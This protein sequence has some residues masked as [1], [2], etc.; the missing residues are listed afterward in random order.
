MVVTEA[1]AALVSTTSAKALTGALG[2]AS[3]RLEA[4]VITTLTP[5]AAQLTGC[6]LRHDSTYVTVVYIEDDTNR[7]DGTLH[8]TTTRT[9]IGFSN[10][11][12]KLPVIVG[13]ASVEN[14]TVRFTAMKASGRAWAN[15]VPLAIAASQTPTAVMTGQNGMG[16][17]L[18]KPAN[19]AISTTE[20]TLDL[21]VCAM[22]YSSDY[23]VAVYVS[24]AGGH[25][26][27]TVAAASFS[28]PPSSDFV[29]PPALTGSIST[30][31]ADITFQA[32]VPGRLWSVIVSKAN[33]PLVTLATAKSAQLWALGALSCRKIAQPATAG[34]QTLSFTGCDLSYA[35]SYTAFTYIED[36]NGVGDGTLSAPLDIA[37]PGSS[38]FTTAPGI[39]QAQ[40]NSVAFFFQASHTGSALVWAVVG[41]PA[42]VA[43]L[44]TVSVK[45]GTG[46]ICGISGQA[47]TTGPQSMS[48]VGCTLE[49]GREYHL[50]AYIEAR[51]LTGTLS[52]P[53]TVLVP[54]SN[55]FSG[56][57]G[58]HSPNT[59]GVDVLFA[60]QTVGRAWGV[61]VLASDAANVSISNIKAGIGAIGG[62]CKVADQAVNSL[63]VQTMSFTGCSL[64]M[65][66]T[67]KAFVYVEDGN[68]LEDGTLSDPIDVVL[69]ASNW[70][71][72]GPYE[73]HTPTS[74]ATSYVLRTKENGLLWSMITADLSSKTAAEIKAMTVSVGGTCGVS[75]EPVQYTGDKTIN[76][77]GCSLTAG[78]TYMAH[79]YVEDALGNLDGT[80]ASMPVRVAPASPGNSFQESPRL[81][82]NSISGNG[83]G[84]SYRLANAG[85]VHAIVV[86][87]GTTV[88]VSSLLSGTDAVGDAGCSYLPSTGL[89]QPATSQQT[90][91]FTGCSLMGDNI[92]E[93][94]VYT[95]DYPGSWPTGAAALDGVM[96]G[97]IEI[98]IPFSNQVVGEPE[99][100]SINGLG[101][102]IKFNTTAFHGYAWLTVY[103]DNSG[104]ETNLSAA[105]DISSA[106]CGLASQEVGSWDIA[107]FQIT[108]CA[109]LG[110]VQYQVLLLVEDRNGN[111][112]GQL[113]ILN[114]TSIGTVPFSNTFSTSPVIS[115]TVTATD[116]AVTYAAG[117]AGQGFIKLLGESA[118]QFVDVLSLEAA[119]ASDVLCHTPITT[120]VAGL[121]S[122]R[123]TGCSLTHG[124][125]YKVYVY[126]TDS[127]GYKDGTLSSPLTALVAPGRSNY[128]SQ[129]AALAPSTLTTAGFGVTFSVP[130]AGV[131]WVVAVPATLQSFVDV[132]SIT[133][134]SGSMCYLSAASVAA[135]A[136]TL[137]ITS[138]GF[139][140]A[141]DYSVF[142]YVTNTAG[143]DDGT[144]SSAVP[145]YISPSNGFLTNPYLTDVPSSTVQARLKGN[146]SS[147]YA[148]AAVVPPENF[149]DVTA[150]HIKAGTIGICTSGRLNTAMA[151]DTSFTI[152]GCSLPV[153]VEHRLYTYS[154]DTN[155]R[156]DG[157]L[158]QYVP[159][160]VPA[161]NSFL[162]PVV[163]DGRVSSDGVTLKYDVAETGKVWGGIVSSSHSS[164]VTIDAIR[165]NNPAILLGGSSCR[166]NGQNKNR[167][168]NTV[169]FSGCTLARSASY[170]AYIYV[171]DSAGSRDGTL[172]TGVNFS[173]AASNGFS[174]GL[175]LVSTATSDG[176]RFAFS[177]SATIGRAW[178]QIQFAQ[179]AA[180]TTVA[181][182]KAA[183]NAI[184]S[185]NC[186]QAN[187]NVG[188]SLLYWTLSGC[189][190]IPG[191]SYRTVLYV[192]DTHGHAD[193]TLTSVATVVPTASSNYFTDL[194]SVVGSATSD[195]VTVQYT[196][197]NRSGYAWAM[198]L[199]PGAADVASVEAM[200]LGQYSL[201]G[202][203]CKP[204]AIPINNSQ[205]RVLLSNCALTQ[206]QT[207][208]VSVY[209]EGWSPDD[210]I[211]GVWHT[212]DVPVPLSPEVR[213]ALAR[214]WTD[215][216]V[217]LGQD[218]V[219][220][221]RAMNWIGVG[222][223]SLPSS[224][225]R[226]A[227]V[228]AAPGI[229]II[230][231]R[232]LTSFN[233]QWAQPSSLGAE[234]SS[235][236]LFMS[237]PSDAGVF[238]EIY[239]G[240]DTSFTKA[241]LTTGQVYSFR[242]S[243]VNDL[244]EGSPSGV[245]E[246][247][248]C[249]APSVPGPITVKSRSTL[250]VTVQWAP[251]A[252]TGG[253]PI[254][255]YVV[256]QNG[257]EASRQ[258]STEFSL[259]SVVPGQTYTFDLHA[260]SQVGSSAKHGL[261]TVVAAQAPARVNPPRIT[262]M[263][264]TGIAL[265]WD[266][267]P[268]L[269]N[270]GVP[271]TGYRVYIGSADQPYTPWGETNS[272]TTNAFISSLTAGGTYCFKVAALNFVTES[273]PLSDQPPALSDAVCGHA[274]E[275]PQP[276]TA[277]YFEHPQAGDIRVRWPPSPDN[278]G[279]AVELYELIM[280][281]NAQGYSWVATNSASDLEHLVEG[282]TSGQTVYFR[283]RARN[284]VGW[285]TYGP[286]VATVCAVPPAQ[287]AAPTRASST[288][289]AITVTWL[290]P[291]DMGSP[292]RQYRLYQAVGSGAFYQVYEGGALT[293]ESTGLA[294]G[295][296][297][298]Y[299][300]TAV[301]EAGEGNRSA[302]TSMFCAASPGQPTDVSFT[303]T[304]RTDTVVS[305]TPPVDDGGS[306]IVRYE[307]WFRD[308]LTTGPIDKLAW[309]GAG[310]MSDVI[311]FTTGASLQV[312]VAA[313]NAVAEQHSLPGTRSD[314]SIYYAAVLPGPPANTLMS[315]STL[316][317]ATLTWDPPTDNG[318]LPIT[319]YKVYMDDALGGPLVQVYSGTAT[320]YQ[321]VG[322]ATGYT[323]RFEVRALSAKGEG[324]ASALNVAPC[325]EPGP[326]GNLRV[327]KRT[328]GYI[329]LGWDAPTDTGECPILGYIVMSGTSAS[330]AKVGSTPSVL[331]TAF[332]FVP[333][334]PDQSFVFRVLAENW[335][336]RVSSSFVG[337][338]GTDLAVIGAA[339]PHAPTN[340]IRTGG[341][342]N[343]IDL[344]WTAPADN[345]GSPITKYSIRRNDGL[346]GS[347][348]TDATSG[349][350]EP[351]STTYTVTGLTLG[352]YYA[353]QVAAANRVL[354]TNALQDL[355]PN[356]T[357]GFFYAAS[358]PDPPSSPTIVAG[359]RT[360]TGVDVEWTAPSNSGG[361]P[362]LGYKLYRDNGANDTI[363]VLLW[364]GVG[365]PHITK[366][367]VSGL[368][369]GLVYRLAT[370]AVNGAGESVQA[371]PTS[372]PG[373]TVPARMAVLQRDASIARTSTGVSLT[374][375]AA[376]SDGGSPI[377][378]YEIRYDNGAYSSLSNTRSLSSTTFSDTINGLPAGQFVR[379]QIYAQ[380]AI[381]FSQASPV[382][383]TQICALPDPVASFTAS[384][385]TDDSVK[386]TWTPPVNTGCT[387]ALIKGYQVFMRQ[388]SNAYS[389]VHDGGPSVLS[390]IQRG[391]SAGASYGF[392]VHVCASDS[393]EVGYPTGGLAVLAGAT[394]VFTDM[395]FTLVGTT[396][397]SIEI[398]WT[399][400]TGLPILEYRVYYDRGQPGGGNIVSLMYQGTATSKLQDTLSRGVTYRFQVQARNAN[401]WGPLSGIGS[402]AA[403]L[404][405]GTV[406]NF[407][408]SSSTSQTLEV[409]W[410]QPAPV[411]AN[412]ASVIRYE[413]R[414][415][416]Q[417]TVS[418][419]QIITTS[420][421]F[422][423]ASP[424]VPLEAG[425]TYRFQVRA[426]NINACGA[427]TSN[428][429][430]VC[431]SLP[432]AP[433]APYVTAS[434]LTSI[435]LGWDFVGKD[436]GGVPLTHYNIKASSDGGST[437][438]YAGSTADASVHS[439]NYACGQSQ[440]FFFKVAAVNGVGGSGGEG[441]ES[442]PVGIYCAPPPLTPQPPPISATASTLTVELYDPTPLQLSTASHTGW[443][444]LV[445]D[446]NDADNVYEETAV[447]DTT[448]RQY[449][450]T[451]G[452]VTG[453]SYR[454]KLKLCSVVGCSAESQIG[455]PTIAASPPAAPAPVYASDSSDTIL[456]VAWQFSGSNG[457]SPIL[458]WYVYI[459]TD[460]ETWPT[461]AQPTS[462]IND[463]NTMQYAY[464]CGTRSQQMLW[465]K[466]AGYSAAGTGSLSSTLPFRCSAV[467]NAPGAP[468]LSSSSSAHITIAWT[469]PT[470]T[471]L[472]GALHRGTKVHFD[473]GAGGPF[474][475]ITL[476]DTLQVQYTRTG[477]SAGQTY[478][479]RIQT[480]SETGDSQTSPILSAVA[481]SVPD[482]PTVTIASTSNTALVYTAQLL[483]STGG[484]PILS[485][486]AYVSGDGVTFPT[487][488]SANLAATF[489][490]YTVDCTN[491]N[492]V[493]RSEQYF[494]V[495]MAAVNRAGE[496]AMSSAV[497]SRCSAVPVTPVAPGRATSTANSVTITFDVNGVNG[498]NG[499]YLL[500]FKVHTDDGNSGPWSTDTITDTTL[501]QFTK[502]GLSP[503]LNYRFKV[504]VVSEV[505]TSAMSTIS[506]YVSAATPDPP[507]L[508]VPSSE[509]SFINL[510]WTPGSDGGS[511]IT[512]WL[513]Y[514]SR[515]GITW[516]TADQPQ[517]I[518]SN[519]N[520]NTQTISCTDDTKWDGVQVQL[521]YVFFRV[522]GV[523]A[524]GTGVPSNSFRWRCSAKPG[525]P[526]VPTKVRGYASA[527]T[528]SYAPTQLNNAIHMG[529]KI[530]YDDG[531]NGAYNEVLVTST[532]SSE[533]TAAGLTAGL[534]YRFKVR[535]VSE[536]GESD[537]SP[538][539][540]LT[541][542]A[543]ADPPSAPHY[544][545]S[546]D[547]QNL[548]FGWTFP[549]SNGGVPITAWNVYY[550]NSFAE[551]G[552]P[553]KEVPNAVVPAGTMQVTCLTCDIGTQTLVA[554]F[555]YIRVAAVTA[556]GI[557]QYSPIS[558][559]FCANR[560]DPPTVTDGSGTPNSI[561]INIAP[562]ALHRA[563][564]MAFKIYMDDGLGGALTYRGQVED[565][566]QGYYTATGLVTDRAYKVQV[567][568]VSTVAESL[569]SAIVTV[570]SCGAPSQPAP[571]TRK[572]S[573]SNSITLQ[574]E[575][576]ADNGCPMTGYRIYQQDLVTN[577]IDQIYPG[578]GD[579]DNPID[580]ILSPT[581]LEFRK[582]G[583]TRGRTYAFRVRAYNTRGWTYSEW[584]TI[585]CASEPGAMTEP[586][587]EAS[588]GSAQSIVLT[589]GANT[590]M[591]GGTAVGYKVFRNN[592]V[593]TEIN[594]FPDPTCGMETNPAPQRCTI[595]GL[596]P[597]ET[598]QIRMLAINE[599]GEGPLS[600][601]ATRRAAST[602]ATITTLR[603][604]DS[605]LAPT[606]TFSWV[607]PAS[608]GAPI[609]NYNG[610]L[611]DVLTNTVQFWDPQ[612]NN[613][614]KR[615]NP[616]TA[617][618]V[619]LTTAASVHQMSSL[620]GARQYKFRIAAENAMGLGEWS[621]WS[622]LTEAPRGFT[623]NAPINPTN[624]GRHSDPAR[625]G[626]I[627]LGWDAINSVTQT[628]GD[629]V[630]NIRYEIFA[631][632]TTT[633]LV[634]QVMPSDTDNFFEQVVP[635]GQ[636]MWYRLRAV[637]SGGRGSPWSATVLEDIA[638]VNLVSA[639][640]PSQATISALTSTTA[641][642][643]VVSFNV[644]ASN[645]NSP[646]TGYEVSTTANF[647]SA[648]QLANTD[649][650]TRIAGLNAGQVYT[651]RVRAKN[652]V[653]TGPEDTRQ[654][655]ILG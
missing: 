122:S 118:P 633:N 37:V 174:T 395:P 10:G 113:T 229:P 48:I 4:Q 155:D 335:K 214:N 403:S 405:P 601:I 261:F 49:R 352:Y 179:H 572:S 570:R 562:N 25:D 12:A 50:V 564:M 92:Y 117:N 342:A 270:G 209:V 469:M 58:A 152:S 472:H 346:G 332:T 85:R 35:T 63:A 576:P 366:F 247:A 567:T 216:G 59:G 455:G 542:G 512:G 111:N 359:S 356:Y 487:S 45:I 124:Y 646:I 290:A 431:G 105:R 217:A 607:A 181:Q 473:D 169:T 243:A 647:A 340:L 299:Q 389:Q 207:Y 200:K 528:L 458:G 457:G 561:T 354:E 223:V 16:S 233:L 384:D 246:A 138:C 373:G 510:A 629:L 645:G 341:G 1:E 480:I 235:Y 143:G 488:P 519:G 119:P 271:V 565:T 80:Q 296:T 188:T 67:H 86:P 362:V 348:F 507:V 234:I 619:T 219:Y 211:Q 624:F 309:S 331:D 386:L 128:F 79:F 449:T 262:S 654:V 210:G 197:N 73:V 408:Y 163:L 464:P 506:T 581:T 441:A 535:V 651:V 644:P 21:E 443:R 532:S 463:V 298:S 293:F 525:A 304:S 490:S 427:Y 622:S 559:I 314:T 414:W 400:P 97:P 106:L 553:A 256:M 434:T 642:E 139:E 202:P 593:G 603:N 421:A 349:T 173:V 438:A 411:H 518:I 104:V 605:S 228:P 417:T 368:T 485:W 446:A 388:G 364:N 224:P 430:L 300:V 409:A 416:D 193:G 154:E 116:L 31:G 504:Q 333:S 278:G 526:N 112:D 109:L 533:Y 345:G 582:T 34:I 641:G 315:A 350:D 339:A 546:Y 295:S 222:Q 74:S 166:L 650:Q 379:F 76:M 429:D 499:A 505:G 27:G 462:T 77:N 61:V 412:E 453:H 377:I 98:N 103:P 244:G 637:N 640:V 160:K 381:G 402:Y 190:L 517:Y 158:S 540:I 281:P 101:I 442:D 611:Y 165:N 549:G 608:Q 195:G 433:S 6:L 167:G 78:Q 125:S 383:R 237:G 391:L 255:S 450:F 513:V 534:T 183:T 489:T 66:T 330:M 162:Q 522:S 285:G 258:S 252:T 55:S 626:Y 272:I 291:R 70:L 602:P 620:V 115:S 7:T 589:W 609:Y 42:A 447:Y 159:V 279:A 133:S 627:K 415:S 260:E 585:K 551:D 89:I 3:C 595:T 65:N 17:S 94:Y 399:V 643:A 618:E 36:N 413:V 276:P 46:T 520:T 238:Q 448:F 177:A 29:S 248:A 631:G 284:A 590:P 516:K 161:S 33:A 263:A 176:V 588:L 372:I 509:N 524:A 612:R 426:C 185:P 586:S 338:P 451:S 140:A 598:Y 215:R 5:V 108:G 370:T 376:S 398:A 587:Q 266:G 369:G 604:S 22:A 579:E 150:A 630:A 69:P 552:W 120:V 157:S 655:T 88:T 40:T 186:R 323:Y 221:V 302:T 57:P 241:L 308:G 265:D 547:N 226:A 19:V 24:D 268:S 286:A 240:A 84:L 123:L 597:G 577:A 189:S 347:I 135:G 420:P 436:N 199:E 134:A 648:I 250:D 275:P 606:L 617:T 378:G 283:V 303:H 337:A 615:E 129:V 72:S 497:K 530:F 225:I 81:V 145:I 600:P 311:T 404:A 556:A 474:T 396:Q 544:V 613:P 392:M 419:S 635:A 454:V 326:I 289:T 102:R 639:E 44:D 422:K 336:T 468:T 636:K 168:M 574:W 387:G 90:L 297:Y 274:A 610:E 137:S 205:Q 461:L 545:N 175:A 523:N 439:F 632:T 156:N 187:V 425:Y 328:G 26:D 550:S 269:N 358:A 68:G 498:L 483:G 14:I 131:A 28:T 501:R 47:I 459:S 382:Y 192:E 365:Q 11:F 456:T 292:I 423:T 198:M 313:V 475:I 541:I 71:T 20:V 440:T 554:D 18:C 385:H 625:S 367:S 99:I 344:S 390:H 153:S 39:M 327:L 287:M 170:E 126:I 319:G 621:E 30:D 563:E 445:D 476:T 401:G 580:S 492:G 470:T 566:S 357:Q 477:V 75:S 83:F 334:S 437:Y 82:S 652:A 361:I 52:A 531:Q 460:G 596:S 394:P 9:P 51:G 251:P 584:V 321:K 206:G 148:W 494:W 144:I 172:S 127:N 277:T 569:P 218:H 560:P 536:V 594:T 407:R 508:Y 267:L 363:D 527:V 54:T 317:S 32:S 182:V 573:T 424:A 114:G 614:N 478:R 208:R 599:I 467:P 41:T 360:E 136:N 397:T 325:N 578:S 259:P 318:G 13:D 555:V 495:K 371:T 15:V 393:C 435:A 355:K 62:V 264:S 583:L 351:T 141:T 147:G 191:T 312:Q 465:V 8:K 149:T 93:A 305:W 320:M 638:T 91:T 493:S 310:T 316:V 548:V 130:I 301:N 537:D 107:E 2:E 151:S 38:I 521:Q 628:G 479:F 242:V 481:A 452:I 375:T 96:K 307:V 43:A 653:G 212:T 482:A 471:N 592:G 410:D 324:E 142:V 60:T 616:F 64:V 466:V 53:V 227:S 201:G 203:G 623:L 184:G 288:R 245:R 257:V 23:A 343:S 254:T 484:T 232:T 634:Q 571:P 511:P 558:R 514:G 649:T 406:A 146:K 432:E 557:G 132:L 539:L 280:N 239:S 213:G 444:I 273:N 500:A 515:D 591:N 380:N 374:W 418:D 249:I 121:Q 220:H 282:C 236:R 502:T 95:D 428:L 329:R 194:P 110:G 543:D 306:D 353:F 322:M 231:A 568:V 491:F 253:C 87:Q 538:V 486:N 294:T 100:V 180:T 575:A 496:G 171:E 56:T 503:G 529:Y 230:A 196:A 164:Q 178:A 204:S